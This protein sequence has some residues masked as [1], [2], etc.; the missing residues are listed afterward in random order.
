MSLLLCDNRDLL[1][2]NQVDS[3]VLFSQECRYVLFDTASQ[4]C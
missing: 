1:L 4:V 2:M 3:L